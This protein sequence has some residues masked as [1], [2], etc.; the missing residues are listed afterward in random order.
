MRLQSDD[1]CGLLV[2]SAAVALAICAII[3]ITA[4]ALRAP[5]I[6]QLTARYSLPLVTPVLIGILPNFDYARLPKP[7]LAKPF[8][9]VGLFV[10]LVI[11]IIG[12]GHSFYGP[13]HLV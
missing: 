4:N 10:V 5:R 1:R 3:Y 6:D 13:S 7:N 9:Q 12:L 8:V 11:T 2:L